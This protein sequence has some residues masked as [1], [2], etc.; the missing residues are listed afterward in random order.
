MYSRYAVSGTDLATDIAYG[1]T[2]QVQPPLGQNYGVHTGVLLLPI[3]A[4]PPFMPGEFISGEFRK[5]AA[6]YGVL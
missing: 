4:L 3:M 6:A 2:V 1:A 5:T